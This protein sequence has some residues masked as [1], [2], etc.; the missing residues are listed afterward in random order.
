M[1]NGLDV[2]TIALFVAHDLIVTAAMAF[3]LPVTVKD[4]AP[5]WPWRGRH[6]DCEFPRKLDGIHR[7]ELVDD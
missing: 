3:A 2:L 7:L 4:A 6:W 1:V 5:C